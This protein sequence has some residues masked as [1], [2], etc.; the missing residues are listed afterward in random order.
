MQSYNELLDEL[1]GLCGIVPDYWDV[2][3]VRHEASAETKQAILAAMRMRIDSVDAL[4]SEIRELRGRP[5]N[6]F[7]EPVKVVSERAQPVELPVYIPMREGEESRLSV[8]WS[9]EDEKGGRC[10]FVVPTD[11]IAVEDQSWID[12]V[13]Y[14]KIL[15]R[16]ATE[17]AIGYYSVNVVCEHPEAV[18][19]GEKNFLMKNSRLIITPDQCF[20]PPELEEGKAWGPVVNL[21]SVRSS[22]NWGNGDFADLEGLIKMTADLGGGFV[23]INP[24]HAIPNKSPYGISPYSP[25]SR[26]YKNF[27]YLSMERIADIADSLE[28]RAV[29]N[30]DQFKAALAET[31]CDQL[32]DYKKSAFLKKSLLTYAFEHFYREHYL[33]N[34]ERGIAFRLFVLNEG[35]D[36]ASFALFLALWEHMNTTRNVYVWQDWP[37]EYCDEQSAAV[38]EFRENNEKEILLHEY[39]QWLI[40]EQHREAAALALELGMPVGIYH[41]LAIGSIGGGSNAW[42]YKGLIGGSVDV[43]APPD[44]FNINGQ[45]WGFPPM[46]PER[47]RET[48]YEFFGNIIRKN[49]KYNGALR[50]DHA[51]GMFRLFWIPGGMRA[52][53]G[54]YVKYPVE[55]M[56]RII[57]LESVRNKTMVIAEDLGTVGENVRDTL[58]RFRM[59]S[60]RLLYFERNYPDPSFTAP[61][62]YPPGAL[63]AVTTHDLPTL[64]GFWVGRDLEIKQQL[65]LFRDEEVRLKYYSER[66]RDKALLLCG[67]KSL[68]LLPAGFSPDPASAPVM[69]GEL[70][71]AVY[72]YLAR[73][74]CKLVAVNLDDITGTLNQQNMPGTTTEHPNWIQKMPVSLEELSSDP[75]FAVLADMFRA[76]KR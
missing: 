70:C 29:M 37:E 55:D 24:L 74:P 60:Y 35:A 7:M 4:R 30:S 42:T 67:L 10:E 64:Y 63:C 68:G 51:L 9:L 22:R 61:E 66:E 1:A 6:N 12:G 2:F 57:A 40:D 47:L 58:I 75:H 76:N 44:D 20:M 32:I 8:S 65:K 31:R 26:L 21:Y 49:M 25:I 13:R 46:A 72:S 11:K 52:A 28:A 73:T 14:I 36:L 48:G 23:G 45:N 3:G 54:A 53:D 56:L 62:S 27:I 18:F 50:I 59:L 34:S 38:R 17:R 19:P 71:T 43:G 33:K 16:D 5:W 15:L 39:I 41:D 69:T